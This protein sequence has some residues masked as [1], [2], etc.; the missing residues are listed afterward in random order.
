MSK[1]SRRVAVEP[2]PFA[3]AALLAAMI[4]TSVGFYGIA[5]RNPD[6]TV[7]GDSF[8]AS[9]RFADEA[10]AEARA[11]AQ[12]WTLDVTTAANATGVAVGARLLGADGQ[13]L[14]ADRLSVRR[15]R[16]AEGGFDAD[17]AIAGDEPI[18]VALPRTG[19]W[20]LTVRAERGD[21][22]V[23]RQIATWMP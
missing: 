19:R 16:P 11:S 21:A 14:V 17:F 9:A 6:P 2:W 7:A 12:G 23:Q 15:E 5:A 10:R 13:P 1:A 4:G 22:V 3:L 8:Q 20:S 18:E